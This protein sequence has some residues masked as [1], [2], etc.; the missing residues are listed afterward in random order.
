MIRPATRIFTPRD[1]SPQRKPRSGR[2]LPTPARNRYHAIIGPQTM[3]HHS[4]SRSWIRS[5][6]PRDRLPGRSYGRSRERCRFR[7][8]VAETRTGNAGARTPADCPARPRTS[9]RRTSHDAGLLD[10][11]AHAVGARSHAVLGQPMHF[12]VYQHR[13]SVACRRTPL[14]AGRSRSA[15][16]AR[17]Q[18]QRT[19]GPCSISLAGKRLFGSSSDHLAP[20]SDRIRIS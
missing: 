12:S 9:K 17:A 6:R 18:S 5:G 14:L 20:C 7:A 13:R 2:H 4:R 8:S 16:T 3:V 11:S 1:I 15:C 19:L 10:R